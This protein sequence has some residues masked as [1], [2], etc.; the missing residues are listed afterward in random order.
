M[1]TAYISMHM[2]DM[3]GIYRV[4]YIAITHTRVEDGE[5]QQQPTKL[6]RD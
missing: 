6:R 3:Y 1:T 5:R 2:C 4:A